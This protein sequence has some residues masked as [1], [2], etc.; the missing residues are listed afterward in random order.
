[1]LLF[2]FTQG[3][4]IGSTCTTDQ[5]F[6]NRVSRRRERRTFPVATIFGNEAC[7]M[8]KGNGMGCSRGL[9]TEL[10]NFSHVA[11]RGSFAIEQQNDG[12]SRGLR[13]WVPSA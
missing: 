11:C 10:S 2:A 12:N 3:H 1:M 7:K 6:S 4:F 9:E 8:P 13:A 5:S